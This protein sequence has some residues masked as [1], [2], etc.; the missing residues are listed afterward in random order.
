MDRVVGVRFRIV[1]RVRVSV[2]VVDLGFELGLIVLALW[3]GWLGSEVNLQ[4]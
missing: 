3:L 1:V 2:S 4:F